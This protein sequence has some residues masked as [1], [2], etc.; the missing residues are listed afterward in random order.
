[1]KPDSLLCDIVNTHDD[2]PWDEL[3]SRITLKMGHS[4]KVERSGN[5]VPIT[6]KGKLQ[7]IDI[8]IGSR[9]GNKKVCD[10]NIL[11]PVFFFFLNSVQLK[12]YYI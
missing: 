3:F 6:A 2:I 9:S 5:N 7:P 1:M 10:I 11:F 8:Q 12:L 4:Y